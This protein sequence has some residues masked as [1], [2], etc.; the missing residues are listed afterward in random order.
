[1][2]EP[3][4]PQTAVA[5]IREILLGDGYLKIR[6]HC[7]IRMGERTIDDLDI[8]LVLLENGEIYSKP[9]W[10][11]KHQK[12]K[13]SIDGYDT[14]NEKI[15]VIVNIVEESWRVVAISAIAKD[16]KGVKK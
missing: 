9:E 14:E 1:M 5:K 13:Y 16:W 2:P 6:D 12:Y 7:Y 15:R 11:K 8:Q 4:D 3:Y 10:D